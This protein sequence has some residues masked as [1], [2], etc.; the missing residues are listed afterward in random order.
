M[1]VMAILA[2]LLTTVWLVVAEAV[3]NAPVARARLATF[4]RRHDLTVTA[5][6]GTLVIRYLATTRRWR[7][8]GLTAGFLASVAWALPQ[9]RIHVNFLGLFAGWFLGALVAE[10]RVAHLAGGPR[11]AA[12]LM[13]RR[14]ADYR[15][16][17]VSMLLPASVTA[18]ATVAVVAAIAG[19]TAAAGFWFA[20]ALTVLCGVILIQQRVLRRPQPLA[21]PDQLAADDAIR[22]RSLHVLAAGGSTLVW[23]CV[24]GQLTALQPNLSGSVAQLAEAATVAGV[25]LAPLA[26]LLA[27]SARWPVVPRVAF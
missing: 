22:S 23:Y 27:A 7:A 25:L 5:T 1:F 11:R 26:G 12:S 14:A 24:V 18:S 20:A 8:A 3:G 10:A 19:W 2:L 21:P 9:Q 6:N 17:L 16:A 13:P 4:A 15:S